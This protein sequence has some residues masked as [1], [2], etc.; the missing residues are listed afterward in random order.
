M[1]KRAAKP[2]ASRGRAG[3]RQPS[4]RVRR[5]AEEAH[6]HILEA[7]ERRLIAGGPEA[8]RLQDIAA[9]V[10]I[11]HPAILHHFGSRE[12]LL[13]ALAERASQ[14]LERELMAIL[15][16]RR[17]GDSPSN[18]AERAQQMFERIH[19]LFA[20][21]GYARLF[22]GLLLSRRKPQKR[23]KGVFGQFARAMHDNRVKRRIEDGRP[24]PTWE[25]TAFALTM[26]WIA[27]FGD[28][29]FGP[30]ARASVGLP[31]DAETGRK[32]RRW[33]AEAIEGV[34][35]NTRPRDRVH[36]KSPVGS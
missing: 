15:A 23:M 14:G 6:R 5:T 2:V 17:P 10:G 27:L 29:L 28:A 4:R 19:E 13:A 21:R 32:F 1:R 20:D 12:G 3:G 24:I 30:I 18:R 7:T 31:D 26:V 35:P 8:V 11:S 34:R 36:G 25:E 22:A 16:T 9:D 33:M